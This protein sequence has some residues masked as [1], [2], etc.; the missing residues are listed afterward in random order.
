MK[1]NL[2]ELSLGRKILLAGMLLAFLCL[3][4][5]WSDVTIRGK[6]SAIPEGE[7]LIFLPY[8]YPIIQIIRGA[9]LHKIIGLVCVFLPIAG[10]VFWI[11]IYSSDYYQDPMVG[12]FLFTFAGVIALA[13]LIWSFQ[14]RFGTV[15][16]RPKSENSKVLSEDPKADSISYAAYAKL[17]AVSSILGASVYWITTLVVNSLRPS[18]PLY[19]IMM[20][21]LTIGIIIVDIL[22]GLLIYFLLLGLIRRWLKGSHLI[23][24]AIFVGLAIATNLLL[25]VIIETY[26]TSSSLL[27]VACAVP[28]ALYF[29]SGEKMV[30]SRSAQI[31]LLLAI[32]KVLYEII[33]YELLTGVASHFMRI[34]LFASFVTLLQDGAL[35]LVVIYTADRF[36]GQQFRPLLEEEEIGLKEY[37]KKFFNRIPRSVE[38]TGPHHQESDTPEEKDQTDSSA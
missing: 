26:V 4:L 20:T 24:S 37:L 29:R 34:G 33:R 23:V 10:G 27:L 28:L 22:F 21:K 15:K 1:F 18:E 38:G 35:M 11:Y 30:L 32:L 5:P 19:A 9:V 25:S 6:Q 17:A 8:L 16:S 13:G 3:F 2:S 7:F 12:G 36:I 31:V 14:Q